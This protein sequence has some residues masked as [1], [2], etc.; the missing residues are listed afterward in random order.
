MKSLSV[1]ALGALALLT[2]NLRAAPGLEELH[3]V[4]LNVTPLEGQADCHLLRMPDGSKVLIDAADAWDAPGL[5]VQLL[6]RR[7]IHHL[8]LVVISHFHRDHYG[9]LIDILNAG[10]T[11]GRVILNVPDKEIADK[12]TPWGCDWNE[13]QAVLAELRQRFVSYETPKAGD[14]L[15]EMKTKNGITAGID[16]LCCYDGVHTPIGKTDVN[17]TSIILRVFFGNTRI[18]FTGDLNNP[19]GAYLAQSDLDL[20][21]DLLKVPHHGTE[22]AA[23]NEFFDRVGAKAVLIP[24]PKH[25]WQSARSMRIRNYFR[26]KNVPTYVSGIDGTVRVTLTKDG[27]SIVKIP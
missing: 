3:W 27:Y 8:D 23:P 1:L 24:S 26:E 5:L 10:I 21:A 11:I 25:L 2:P 7:N 17:D 20:K 18:L 14:R 9:R 19:L 15:M 13:A 6:Q 4:M 16:V 22:G 12:E